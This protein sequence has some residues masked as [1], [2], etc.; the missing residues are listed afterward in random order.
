M[1]GDGEEAGLA[2][3]TVDGLRNNVVAARRAVGEVD[4]GNPQRAI[5]QGSTLMSFTNCVV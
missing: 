4:D 2:Q 3:G 1:A 5:V